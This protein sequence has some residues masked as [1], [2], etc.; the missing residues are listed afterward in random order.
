VNEDES[1]V[2]EIRSN[3]LSERMLISQLESALI[4][5]RTPHMKRQLN[6]IATFMLSHLQEIIRK[7]KQPKRGPR[8]ARYTLKRIAPLSMRASRAIYSKDNALG[9]R[10]FYARKRISEQKYSASLE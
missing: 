9:F 6:Q 1:R 3:A 8:E 4:N 2:H 10:P 7:I 5:P